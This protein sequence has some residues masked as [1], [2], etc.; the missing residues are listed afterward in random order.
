[1]ASCKCADTSLRR[2]WWVGSQYSRW[3]GGPFLVGSPNL[4]PTLSFSN[5]GQPSTGF[6]LSGPQSCSVFATS[7]S[8]IRQMSE[9]QVRGPKVSVPSLTHQ[10]WISGPRLY[11]MHL[12]LTIRKYMNV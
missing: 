2:S 6:A 8:P 5:E 7:S 4:M 12:L 3:F 11:S 1:M 9:L 10:P